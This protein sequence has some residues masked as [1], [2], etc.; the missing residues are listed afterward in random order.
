[1][2]SFET[3]NRLLDWRKIQWI[4]NMPGESPVK[5]RRHRMIPYPILV[6]ATPGVSPGIKGVGDQFHLLYHDVA[7][8]YGVQPFLQ[9]S[10]IGIAAVAKVGDLTQGVN[11]RIRATGAVQSSL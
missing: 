11:S 4:I 3:P 10:K 8:G 6:N 5:N 2:F 1:M 7:R 9:P